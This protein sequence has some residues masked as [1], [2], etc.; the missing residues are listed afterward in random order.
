MMIITRFIDSSVLMGYVKKFVTL[1]LSMLLSMNSENQ[2]SS[3]HQHVSRKKK[4]LPLPP[5]RSKKSG[6]SSKP[7]SMKAIDHK[8]KKIA[9]IEICK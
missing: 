6:E 5:S 4:P 3:E 1:A 2:D 9:I 8:L 7:M